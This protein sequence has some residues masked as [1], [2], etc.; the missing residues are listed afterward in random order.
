G[1]RG[2]IS[3]LYT[4]LVEGDD[5]D[6]PVS[7]AARAILDGHIVLSRKI[8]SRGHYPAI[9]VLGS[10]SRLK[11]EVM[12]KRSLENSRR[13][14]ELLAYYHENEDL[15]N[16]GAYAAGSN[17]E[18]DLAIKYKNDFNKFLQQGMNESTEYTASVNAL[19]TLIEGMN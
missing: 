11:S 13:M 7:D 9:D 14:L 8:A 4:V 2:S 15:I 16:I 12:N 19:N 17:Q 3:G 1:I 5:L 6:E 18:V 10:V